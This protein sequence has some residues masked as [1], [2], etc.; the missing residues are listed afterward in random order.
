M[1]F[2][3]QLVGINEFDAYSYCLLNLSFLDT[4]AAA[5]IEPLPVIDFVAQILGKGALTR[6]F[7]DS[8][9]LKVMYNLILQHQ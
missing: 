3:Q 7:S 9:H 2:I 5:F 4:S 6:P 1:I 8:D